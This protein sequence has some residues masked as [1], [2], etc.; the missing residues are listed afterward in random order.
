VSFAGQALGRLTG[1]KITPG[2]AQFEEYTSVAST[3]IGTGQDARV[4]R[5]HVCTSIDPGG[6][7]VNLFGCPPYTAG[8]I[9][10]RGT[11][12]VTFAGGSISLEAY[13]ETFDVTGQVG[14]FLTGTARFKFSGTGYTA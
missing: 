14:E 13:L 5:Q 11:L 12:A 7:D 2:T 8:G 6:V 10:S 1:W 4:V 3:V 9:G